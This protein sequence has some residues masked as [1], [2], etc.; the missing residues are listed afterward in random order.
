MK[1]CVEFLQWALPRLHREWKGY[2]RVRKQVCKRIKRRLRALGLDGYQSYV[3]YLENH[4]EEWSILDSFC[5]IT[6][7]RF[8]RDK[9]MYDYLI[10]TA[11]PDLLK[12]KD[13]P[14]RCWSIGSARGEEPYSLA[15]IYRHYFMSETEPFEII[16]SEINDRMIARAKAG[17]YRPG[18]LKDLPE[19]DKKI[20]FVETGG[21]MRLKQE[22]K[23]MTTFIQH[24]I[25]R[26]LN[27]DPFDL[28]LCRNTAAIYFDQSEQIKIFGRIHNLM[29]EKAV[30]ALGSH[31]NLPEVLIRE[32][33]FARDRRD[34][35]VYFR[36]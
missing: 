19:Q 20:A 5:E 14:L 28:V 30:L 25:R 1:D 12:N 10:H 31:E 11:I 27:F 3:R 18:S 35:P 2:R 6:I 9:E 16:A 23:A 13:G 33:R 17:L 26:P 36:R 7:S 24:D 8:F 32:N 4:D 34:L 15:I 21:M 22:Y 29:K